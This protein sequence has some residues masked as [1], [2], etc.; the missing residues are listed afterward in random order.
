MRS[1]LLKEIIEALS[2]VLLWPIL[3]ALFGFNA[4]VLIPVSVMSIARYGILGFALLIAVQ[5]PIFALAI[6]EAWRKWKIMP[7]VD[8]WETSEE[9]WKEALDDYVK[10]VEKETKD[11]QPPS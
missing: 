10:M 5:S 11:S 8:K 6:R 2:T 9:I 3:V 7:A 1:K 4:F